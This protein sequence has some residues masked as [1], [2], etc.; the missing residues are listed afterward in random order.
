MEEKIKCQVCGKEFKQ[1]H[2]RHTK[3]HG[4]TIDEYKSRFPQAPINSKASSHR[5]SKSL[6]NREITWS[7]K[8]A[9]GVKKS[10]NTNQFQ[11]R[12][13]IPL[14]EESRAALSE[15]MMGHEVSEETRKKIGLSGLGRTPWNKGLTK[16]EDDRLVS[17]SEKIREWN[18]EH[19]TDEMREQIS[20]T[21]KKKYA[22]GMDIPQAKGNKRADLQMYFRSRW[23]ANYARILNFEKKIWT[24]EKE[25]FTLLDSSGNIA[26][27]YTP[28]F[29]VDN[30]YIEI[31]GHAQAEDNWDCECSRCERDKL[32]MMLFQEQNPDK[33]LKIV[34]KD[35]YR[36]LCRKYAGVVPNWEKTS[37]DVH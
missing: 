18:K 17:V 31:K 36:Q 23:E 20:Q 35:E 5:R 3:Q 29:F 27:V 12:T 21:L 9:A 25:R 7:D 14:S 2:A 30:D 34:G 26:V 11:G 28:D 16:E 24:Y 19:M 6:K 13:G 1:I 32:K 37:Y 4:L 33:N 10:W 22:D 15:K 8:I